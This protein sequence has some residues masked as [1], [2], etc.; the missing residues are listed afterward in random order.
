MNSTAE[1]RNQRQKRPMVELFFSF[2][3]FGMFL[4]FSSTGVPVVFG[5]GV[6]ASKVRSNLKK[7]GDCTLTKISSKQFRLQDDPGSGSMVVFENSVRQ[8]SY[9]IWEEIEHSAVG[10]PVKLCLISLPTDCP[11]GDERG[12]IYSAADIRTGSKWILPDNQ[13]M[14][15]GA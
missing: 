14:C 13:H 6:P 8:V 2:L 12:K 15:G 4:T 11:A 10:D 9:D 5:S 3:A 7:N 1:G